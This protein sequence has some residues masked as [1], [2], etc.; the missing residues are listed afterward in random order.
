MKELRQ[1]I[2]ALIDRFE[3]RVFFKLLALI[4]TEQP[5]PKAIADELRKDRP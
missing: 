4:S 3:A 5:L 1:A 2:N